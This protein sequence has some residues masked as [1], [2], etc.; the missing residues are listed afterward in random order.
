MKNKK[1]KKYILLAGMLFFIPLILLIVLGPMS[2]HNFSEPL[3]FGPACDTGCVVSDYQIPDFAF[4]NQENQLITRD[5][6]LGKIWV[7]AFVDFEDPN[8]PK[9]TERLLIPNFKFRMEPDIYI[10]CFDPNG[11]SD[12]AAVKA[13][14]TQN[15][16]YANNKSKWQF[17][18]G[19]SAAMD[20]FVRNG[21]LIK[22]L[23]NEAVFR[24]VD[25]G[26]HI[27]GLYG[28][29]EYHFEN[30]MED[31]AILNKKRKVKRGY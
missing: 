3:Y 28:N 19:D 24:A 22:D 29:T 31:I 9:I 14:V 26:G 8:L 11:Y 15:L 18:Q 13:Y 1:L 27:R 21:F 20:A 23:K 16:R 2:K 4:T 5:S 12:T 30:L 25:E 17:L 6:L 7:A 10:V